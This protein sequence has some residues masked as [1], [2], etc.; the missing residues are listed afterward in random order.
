MTGDASRREFRRVW[1]FLGLVFLISWGVGGLYLVFPAPLTAAF[2]P[3]AYGSAAYLLAACSPTLVAVGLTLAFEGPAG[4]ARLG[5]RLLQ[6]TPLWAVALA[7]LALPTIALA[8]SLLAPPFGAWPVRPADVLVATPLILFTTAQILTNSGPLGE[9]LGWRGYALPRLLDRWPPLIAGGALGVIWTIWHIP[10]FLF[11]GIV[12]TPLSDLGWY[13]LGTVALS[14]L[15]T[16]LFLRTRGSVLIAGIIPHFVINGLGVVGAWRTRPAEAIAL[17]LLA[18]ALF[19]FW[20][21]DGR[22]Q[23]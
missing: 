15:M 14:L 5:R 12:A 6:T 3:F 20:P 18:M 13:A 8:L 10:A 17:A 16:W 22:K 1:L 11:S 4:L 23:P 9:E 21:P 7:F 2:G 19:V